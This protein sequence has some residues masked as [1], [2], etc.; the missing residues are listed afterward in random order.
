[1]FLS[2]TNTPWHR[3]Q[4]ELFLNK[5]ISFIEIKQFN[6][7]L[8]DLLEAKKY[9]ADDHRVHYYL[10]IAYLGKGMRDNAEKEFQEAISLK[11]DYSEAHNYL[12]TL[13][14]DKEL[15][16][17]AIIEFDKALANPVYDTPV[18]PLFNS[19]WAYYNKKAYS[20][21]LAKYNQA[22]RTDPATL[23]RPQIEKN[24]GLIYYDQGKTVDAIEHF[25]KSVDLDPSLSDANFFLAE[26]Y[27]KIS[28]IDGARKSFQK[29][30]KLSPDSSFGKRA[31]TYLKSL[32]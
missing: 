31:R 9:S 22:L 30:V 24:I 12:G 23:L 17:K 25:R 16:D 11:E 18:M 6:S 19:G 5:G 3:E 13:Y 14:M 1:M 21:A 4:A 32:K 15:W 2:C 28:D 8:K 27:L 10:G 20:A 7:A 26:C 29:V